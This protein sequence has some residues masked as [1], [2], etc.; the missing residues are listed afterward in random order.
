MFDFIFFNVVILLIGTFVGPL[1]AFLSDKFGRKWFVILSGASTSLTMFAV[2]VVTILKINLY[3]F[4]VVASFLG[5]GVGI[6]LSVDWALAIECCPDEQDT[7]KDMVSFLFIQCEG[8]LV[9]E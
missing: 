6:Y 5:V 2:V 8:N 1:A 7:A 3:L 4:C 9:F